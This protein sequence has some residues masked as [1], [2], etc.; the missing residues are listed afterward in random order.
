MTLFGK[1]AMLK[2]DVS[3]GPNGKATFTG[4]VE[5]FKLGW[6]EVC[7]ASD[8]K[9][10]PFVHVELSKERRLIQIDGKIKFGDSWLM[11][12]FKIDSGTG[13]FD[14]YFEFVAG[15]DALKI[16]VWVTLEG[17]LPQAKQDRLEQVSDGQGGLIWQPQQHISQPHGGLLDG[18]T[19]TVK[20]QV[21]QEI[22]DYLM[23]LANDNLGGERD[24]AE[25]KALRD[26]FSDAESKLR[27]ADSAWYVA[28]DRCKAKLAQVTSSWDARVNEIKKRNSDAQKDKVARV[29][30]L[31]QDE[32]DLVM[33]AAQD[34]RELAE[35]EKG[36]VAAADKVALEAV[37]QVELWR[38]RVGVLEAAELALQ[39]A[40]NALDTAEAQLADAEMTVIRHDQTQLEKDNVAYEPWNWTAQELA[41]KVQV[42]KAKVRVAKD[43]AGVVRD[44]VTKLDMGSL[45]EANGKLDD[46]TG[47]MKRTDQAAR[48]RRAAVDGNMEAARLSAEE[49][50]EA[51]KKRQAALIA[52]ADKTIQDLTKQEAA[53]SRERTEALATARAEYDVNGTPEGQNYGVCY[54]AKRAAEVKL[55]S[56]L[57]LKSSVSASQKLLLAPLRF[58]VNALGTV[59]KKILNIKS[60]VIDGK[61]S[62]NSSRVSCT[63]DCTV[64]GFDY[65]F[66]LMIDLGNIVSLFSA[67]WEKIKGVISSVANGIL[68]FLKKSAAAF[69]EFA[70]KIGEGIQRVGEASLHH[71][72]SGLAAAKN[73]SEEMLKDIDKEI[74]QPFKSIGERLG[75]EF[76]D[77][78]HDVINKV[79][80]LGQDIENTLKKDPDEILRDIAQGAVSKL[81]QVGFL[82]GAGSTAVAGH[83]SVYVGG[84][85]AEAQAMHFLRMQATAERDQVYALLTY[86][87]PKTDDAKMFPAKLLLMNERVR[88]ELEFLKDLHE[89]DLIDEDEFRGKHEELG[90]WSKEMRAELQVEELQRRLDIQ[91]RVIKYMRV[92]PIYGSK[93]MEM[94]EWLRKGLLSDMGSAML[95]GKR[96]NET[97]EVIR[98]KRGIM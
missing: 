5:K 13:S 92:V 66:T 3:T 37:A 20:A 26:A 76:D 75:R 88:E 43:R 12:F 32:R 41:A 14:V 62:D 82:V 34:E 50:R 81:V 93:S 63:V 38:V 46:L 39:Q 53:L 2:A 59:S 45:E 42:E 54:A 15:G 10:D 74:I 68:N 11:L 73:L 78:G 60:I 22:V 18:K 49:K 55:N 1:R 25:E 36:A 98:K 8:A 9:K 67:L 56:Y 48:D 44:G 61:L 64:G 29:A 70:Q 16:K 83:G 51:L 79:A 90:W 84:A 87:Q 23:K 86:G 19:L 97:V 95:D 24:P 72:M 80:E 30:Q 6:L 85:D 71:F 52:H 89:Q 27:S 40:L 4:S 31:D 96:A 17:G 21:E 65:T 94:Q 35:T 28:D 33:K 58:T 77:L 69:R 91:D 57:Q 7:A 47:E